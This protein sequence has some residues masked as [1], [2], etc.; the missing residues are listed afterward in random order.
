MGRRRL[1]HTLPPAERQQ[2]AEL[3]ASYVNDT[4]VE[5]HR[6]GHSWHHA[7]SEQFFIGHR[8]YLD[9]LESYLRQSGNA[10]FVPLPAWDPDSSIPAEFTA[11]KPTDR[12]ATR[13]ALA[14]LS[15]GLP[16]PANLATGAVCA[17]ATVRELSLLTQP[18]HGAVHGQIGG[19]MADVNVSPAAL[20]FWCWHA[21]IDDIYDDWLSCTIE[22]VGRPWGY[23]GGATAR[24]VF[25]GHDAHLHEIAL[26]Q[27][28]MHFDMTG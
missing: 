17:I 8:G 26:T 20:I 9:G 6:A 13:P 5:I 18:W 16:K 28:W 4:I 22:A 19:T 21:F 25:R 23:P 11:V 15:P 7:G 12:G 24:V 14:D 1:L 10:R 3:I 2:L 27:Q